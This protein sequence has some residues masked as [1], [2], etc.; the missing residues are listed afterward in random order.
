M[1]P[2]AG[3][4]AVVDEAGRG[5]LATLVHVQDLQLLPALCFS[6]RLHLLD[7]PHNIALGGQQDEPHLV[8]YVIDHQ[9]K[10]GL[11]GQCGQLDRA[12]HVTVYELQCFT[13]T[14]LIFEGNMT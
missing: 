12:A 8:A 7:H 14:K 3:V 1:S 5:E 11:A 2:H 4:V 9:E 6:L 13:H 10:H